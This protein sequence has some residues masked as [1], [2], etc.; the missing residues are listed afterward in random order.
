MCGC[1]RSRGNSFVSI[2]KVA[3]DLPLTVT[4]ALCSAQLNGDG[5]WETSLLLLLLLLR[6]DASLCFSREASKIHVVP[7]SLV[8]F[9]WVKAMLPHCCCCTLGQRHLSLSPCLGW[10]NVSLKK[11]CSFSEPISTHIGTHS[12]QQTQTQQ[13]L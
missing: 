9:L 12:E 5:F 6:S 1:I 11:Y 8:E 7:V 4:S 2:R 10:R 3:V 13:A